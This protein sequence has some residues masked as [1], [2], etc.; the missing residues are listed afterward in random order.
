MGQVTFGGQPCVSPDLLL[1][2]LR[3]Q[4][5]AGFPVDLSFA[6]RANSYRCPLGQEPGKGWLLLS[7]DSLNSLDLDGLQPLVFGLA[8]K[9][10]IGVPSQAQKV[11]LPS[12]LFVRATCL[13]PGLR[14]DP[15]CPYL[16]EITDRRHL[17][18]ASVID[19]A[20]NVRSSPTT[21]LSATMG[22]TW[23]SMVQDVW[24]AVGSLG[25]FP[26]LPYSPDGTPEGFSFFGG[27]AYDALGVILERL[28]CALQYDPA[29]DT[30]GIVQVGFAD[31][32]NA[33][34]LAKYDKQRIWDSDYV[35]NAAARFPQY[36]RVY[37]PI[38]RDVADQTGLTTYYHI[39][40]ATGLSGA[41]AGTYATEYDDLAAL[42]TGD[43]LTNGSL[44]SSR[45]A[46]RTAKYGQ[47]VQ[48]ARLM[49]GFIGPRG[50]AGLLDGAQVRA[51]TWADRGQ[52]YVTE[53]ER[54]PFVEDVW[55]FGM[56]PGKPALLTRRVLTDGTIA[57]RPTGPDGDD[58]VVLS[59]PCSL[60]VTG[61]NGETIDDAWT[62]QFA[63][64]PVTDGGPS[65]DGCGRIAVVGF[66]SIPEIETPSGSGM[67]CPP[68]TAPGPGDP[69]E[70]ICG[71]CRWL[72][73]ESTG[74]WCEFCPSNCVPVVTPSGSGG[75]GG[76][77]Q[78]CS[79]CAS[80]PEGV[81]S[82]ITFAPSGFVSGSGS[83]AAARPLSA[84]VAV[85][86]PLYDET[87]QITLEVGETL[88]VIAAAVC[89]GASPGPIA[90]A[91]DGTPL[92]VV[93]E[94][95]FSGSSGNQYLMDVFAYTNTGSAALTGTLTFSASLV[96]NVSLA[97]AMTAVSGLGAA[98]SIYASLHDSGADSP[99]NAGTFTAV[100]AG[101]CVLGGVFYNV[102]GPGGGVG[103]QGMA[104]PLGHVQTATVEPGTAVSNTPLILNTGDYEPTSA[105][106]N[107]P[108][109]VGGST[110][111]N[112][113]I[114]L[115]LVF[116]GSAPSSTCPDCASLNELWTLTYEGPADGCLWEAFGTFCNHT[117][118]IWTFDQDAA[119]AWQLLLYDGDGNV[120]ER[121]V[122]PTDSHGNPTLT[123]D[124]RSSLDLTLPTDGS[125]SGTHTACASW[126][127]SITI[128]P[129]LSYII[130]PCAGGGGSGGSGGGGG[131]IRTTC[132]TDLI[133]QPLYA[134]LSN[135]SGTCDCLDTVHSVT[136]TYPINE[137][138]SGWASTGNGVVACGGS[139][140]SLGL[141]LIC[142]GDSLV[143]WQ[144]QAGLTA[145]L[146]VELSSCD[147][148]VLVFDVTSAAG[149]PSPCGIP[150]TGGGFRITILTTP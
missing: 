14:G 84:P 97:A 43:S 21:F 118:V 40:A 96:P 106:S 98:P 91:L 28:A 137:S 53:V 74:E 20:Y 44:L 35:E 37:F 102:V 92:G 46:E 130:P 39:D 132:C 93:Y 100:P 129:Q 9:E 67:G 89:N 29:A 90:V 49:R 34:A 143:D 126:P 146:N 19:R 3:R 83:G 133:N 5:E 57:V 94:A 13:A 135:L 125:F 117:G 134:H 77:G 108:I 86:S 48:M 63:G 150:W 25:G 131:T 71:G 122:S 104:S 109:A 136:M 51:V 11:A 33:A 59:A 64:Q 120:S 65:P 147:P 119:G 27:R 2:D 103:N 54:T 30:F 115:G 22:W 111:S 52:G 149:E 42:Y 124:C 121:Y 58:A 15:A 76:S 8:K 1:A 16:C 114:G 50:D 139:G 101:A 47:R 32:V 73:F 61:D 145:V 138:T 128:N 68:L 26:G 123:W 81:P 72:Y 113:W 105:A 112:E 38:Q 17:A 70:I 66:P 116:A 80:C 78:P 4:Q 12:L 87:R 110:P 148:F 56:T 99:V 95:S 55:P 24:N 144:L 79:D 60:T 7:R 6:G 62:V 10:I 36:L 88:V 141:Q 82:V 85:Y 69:R 127:G 18:R 45:A 142:A 107:V 140:T 23:L 75:S 31:G 41:Q